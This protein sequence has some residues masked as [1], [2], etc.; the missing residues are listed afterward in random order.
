[1]YEAEVSSILVI[2]SL[3][4]AMMSFLVVEEVLMLSRAVLFGVID[5]AK[6]QSSISKLNSLVA[7]GARCSSWIALLF[8]S[9]S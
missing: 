2:I 5:K 1:M 6:G 3:E 7:Q 8:E 4:H 9:R